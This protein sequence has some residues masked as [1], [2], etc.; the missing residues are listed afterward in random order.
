M[1]FLLRLDFA[2]KPPNHAATVRGGAEAAG[3]VAARMTDE[4]MT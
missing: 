4:P 3:V 2:V 1:K